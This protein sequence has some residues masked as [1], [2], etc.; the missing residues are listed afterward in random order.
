MDTWTYRSDVDVGGA[1]VIG[2]HVFA[3]GEHIGDV[4]E[5]NSAV[6]D[7][8]VVVDVG[9]WL[10][11]GRRL[12]PAGAVTDADVDARRLDLDMT[13]A[14]VEA[15][16]EFVAESVLDRDDQYR[17]DIATHYAPWVTPAR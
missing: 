15:A 11:D 6:G 17:R 8:H 9:S 5:E 10:R 2:W 16:P 13:R 12:I 7:A 3:R 14:D 1:D 4:T